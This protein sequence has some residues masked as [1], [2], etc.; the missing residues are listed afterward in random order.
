[1]QIIVVHVLA[2]SLLPLDLKLFLLT[3]AMQFEGPGRFHASKHPDQAVVNAIFCRDLPS[4]WLL[5]GAARR[6]IRDW[7]T[8]P[9]RLGQRC[10]DQFGGLAS[11]MRFKVLEQNVIGRE[12]TL[13]AEW[14][15]K[16]PQV[17]AKNHAVIP[18]QSARDKAGEP[19]YKSVHG[20]PSV[21]G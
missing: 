2:T 7:P 14:I 17:P 19:A 13:H 9:L 1:M 6:Q 8:Q 16:L 20:V 3:I 5:V 11:H 18:V 12:I 10:F 4:Q 21:G 15:R